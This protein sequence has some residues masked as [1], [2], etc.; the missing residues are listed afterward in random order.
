MVQRAGVRTFCG[1]SGQHA[2]NDERIEQL[3]R[4]RSQVANDL[5]KEDWISLVWQR[6]APGGRG[7]KS[8]DAL[9]DDVLEPM[10]KKLVPIGKLEWKILNEW[11]APHLRISREYTSFLLTSPFC[12][13]LLA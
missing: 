9:V 11:A 8:P 4:L 1:T 2:S 5:G 3:R 13:S 6:T 10:R 7:P 12:L